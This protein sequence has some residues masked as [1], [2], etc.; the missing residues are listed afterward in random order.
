MTFEWIML[1]VGVLL[2][3]GT[4]VFVAAEF[5]LVNLDRADLESRRDRGESGLGP[6]IKALR[7][8]S[9]HLSGAQLGITL[10]T[11]LT[12]YTFEPALSELITPALAATPLPDGSVGAVATVI[13]VLLATIGSMVV[14]EL[15]PKNF[16][17]SVPVRAAKLVVPLQAAFTTVFKPLVLLLN[18]SANAIVRALGVEPQEELSGARTAE[19]LSSLVR[20]SATEGT[21]ESEQAALLGRSLQFAERVA[22][23][24]M[25]PRVRL[26]TVRRNDTAQSVIELTRET[27]ISRYP[28]QGSDI[29]DIVGL[30]HVKNA[31]AIPPTERRTVRVAQLMTEPLRVPDTIG[32]G[33]LLPQLRHAPLQSAIVADEYGGTA[34]LTTIEDLIEELIGDVVDEHDSESPRVVAEGEDLIIDA[35]LRPDELRGASGVDVPEGSDYETVAGFVTGELGRLAEPGDEVRIDTGTLRVIAVEERRIDRLR[36]IP[37]PDLD[38]DEKDKE[39]GR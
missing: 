11:L 15:I 20:R 2:T 8:T 5:A 10:T 4:G 14:G 22:E 36:Y 19:E 16:A 26:E 25:T 28:V 6:T 23:D 29:D 1:G 13:G 9:T 32:V 35:S 38:D 12:G 18:T 33:L 3:F 7:I 24:V 37:D 31:Y 39:A 21:L 17:I 34:G 27:G 30:V